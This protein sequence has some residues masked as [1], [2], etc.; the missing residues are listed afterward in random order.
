MGVNSI[1]NDLKEY[2]SNK[3]NKPIDELEEADLL[4]IKR[5]MLKSKNIFEEQ[6]DYNI[7]DLEKLEN[8]VDCI[9]F[10]FSIS[11]EEMGIINKLQ[12]L[13]FLSLDN[14]KISL[15]KIE[16]NKNIQNLFI[17]NCEFIENIAISGKGLKNIK[18]LGNL[19]EKREIDITNFNNL[20]SLENLEIHYY[21]V[22]G[23]ENILNFAPKLKRLNLNGSNIENQEQVILKLKEKMEITTEKYFHLN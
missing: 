16:L 10:L 8:V 12:K 11:E 17:D 22:S 2:I 9:V 21:N 1:S 20:E 14:C 7:K 23:V 3:I 6:T 15:D 19:D 18:I 13:E 5:I 4:E